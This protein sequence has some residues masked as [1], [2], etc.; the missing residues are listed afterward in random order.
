MLQRNNSYMYFDLCFL[1]VAKENTEQI[2]IAC[3][4][5]TKGV[6]QYFLFSLT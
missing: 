5:Y 1:R 3:N 2:V 6:G 4:C